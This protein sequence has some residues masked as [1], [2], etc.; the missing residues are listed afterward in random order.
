[1]ADTCAMYKQH[2]R[3]NIFFHQQDLPTILF[4]DLVWQNI[5]CH[6]RYRRW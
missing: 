5:G 4:A 3:R 2:R 1:M 6:K